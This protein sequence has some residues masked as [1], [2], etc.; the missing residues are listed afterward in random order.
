MIGSICILEITKV[1][2]LTSGK[3]NVIQMYSLIKHCRH[4]FVYVGGNW[5]ACKKC[6]LV[7]EV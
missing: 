1:F 3:R 7:V 2:W 6:P 4:E 5:K